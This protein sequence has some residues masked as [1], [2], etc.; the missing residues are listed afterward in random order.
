MS[1]EQYIDELFA[2]E[3]LGWEKTPGFRDFV[4]DLMS[5]TGTRPRA[6]DVCSM[7]LAYKAG[8]EHGREWTDERP[9]EPGEYWRSLPK[10]RRRGRHHCLP[11]V[12]N[13]HGELMTE[14]LTSAAFR[15]GHMTNQN[16]SGAKWSRRE[17]PADPFEVTG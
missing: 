9:T 4:L 6:G 16:P 7:H 11:V 13:A 8:L 12:L 15:Y 1:D 17:T 10:N 2:R 3:G 5:E 14:D